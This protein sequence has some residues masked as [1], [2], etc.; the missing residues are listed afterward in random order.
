MLPSLQEPH[1]EGGR[2]LRILDALAR[3]W[4]FDTGPETKVV[5]FEVPLGAE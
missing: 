1:D 2:G 4:G 5:W 3:R